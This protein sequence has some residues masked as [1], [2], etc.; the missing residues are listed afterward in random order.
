MYFALT[1]RYPESVAELLTDKV[2]GS[3]PVLDES[4]DP[5]G[6]AYGYRVLHGTPVAFSLGRDGVPGGK[7]EDRDLEL[8]AEALKKIQGGEE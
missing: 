1:G 8:S 2:F 6:H 5:W 3:E 4:I 7:G